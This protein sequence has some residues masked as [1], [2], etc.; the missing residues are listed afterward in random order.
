MCLKKL[1]YMCT[2]LLA[3]GAIRARAN[4]LTAFAG[5]VGG[6]W[7][8]GAN[9]STYGPV[10]PE[11]L[12]ASAA[13]LSV[14]LGGIAFCGYSGSLVTNTGAGSQTAS[15]SL[16]STPLLG[17]FYTGAS[18]A[19]AD[20]GVLHASAAG[21]YTGS[22]GSGTAYGTASGA[23]LFADSLTYHSPFA[24]D[25]TAGFVE[26]T[27]LIH[28]TI[29]SPAGTR[30]DDFAQLNIGHNSATLNYLLFQGHTGPTVAGVVN[31]GPPPAGFTAGIGS[32]TGQAAFT[33]FQLPVTLGQAVDLQVG[34]MAT[35]YFAGSSDFSSTATLSAIALFDS[36]RNFLN[37][38]SI[39]SASGTQYNANGV[40]SASPEPATF[41]LVAGIAVAGL[42][43]KRKSA[44]RSGPTA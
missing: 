39:T 9:C 13:S 1:S 25:G 40:L 26:Y 12:F 16:G 43:R 33:T 24:T 35:A 41:E 23:S 20:Y 17:G 3:F 31:G 2:V 11:N 18:S 19:A 10:S 21:T 32:L 42:I 8:G 44:R 14:P 7:N 6:D 4:S 28:G 37:T 5:I 15:N 29:L 30:S 36:N 38:F 27:F 34:L 22:G